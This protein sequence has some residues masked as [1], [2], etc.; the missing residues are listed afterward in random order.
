MYDHYEEGRA[1]LAF[2]I[3]FFKE[4]ITAEEKHASKLEKQAAK[5]TGW[6][7]TGYVV[8]LPFYN[9]RAMP[10][11]LWMVLSRTPS[12]EICDELVLGPKVGPRAASTLHP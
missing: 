6:T 3:A 7:E 11:W 2:L 9:S 10:L 1:T 5:A 4:R 12:L 8:L